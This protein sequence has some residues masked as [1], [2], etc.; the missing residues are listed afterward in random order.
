MGG[1]LKILVEGWRDIGHSYALVNQYQLA[2]LARRPGVELRHRDARYFLRKW[3]PLSGLLPPAVEAAVRAIPAPE[4]GWR[5]DVGL[6]L[7]VPPDLKA[8]AG[9]ERTFVFTTSEWGTLPAGVLKV[10]GVRSFGEAHAASPAT[11]IT[12]SKWSRQGLIRS[13]GDAGR[14]RVVPHGVDTDSYRPLDAQARAAARAR[15]G[16]QDDFVFLNVGAMTENKGVPQLLRAF[17]RV[18]QRVP[19]AR[20]VLKGS[21]AV[22][23]SRRFLREA[24]LNSLGDAERESVAARVNYYGQPLGCETMARLYQGA[25]AYVSPYLAEGFNLPVLEAIACGLPV[26]CTAGGPTDDFVE[27]SFALRIESD[28]SPF[29]LWEEDVL[30]LVPRQEH[31]EELMSRVAEDD[32]FRLQARETGPA[33]VRERYTWGRVVDRLLEVLTGEVAG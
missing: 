24:L 6:R 9:A 15:L 11:L 21:D 22:F 18:R 25:D 2:E 19:A 12:P 23:D 10:M 33:W 5:A 7:T 29:R 17:A 4:P 13:G 1:G 8:V 27:A 26:L 20:L 31:L 3:S 28:L 32:G 14:I 30:A 16:W